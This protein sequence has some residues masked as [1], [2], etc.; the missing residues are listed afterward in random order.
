MISDYEGDLSELLSQVPS[1]DSVPVLA[2]RNMVLFPGVIVPIMIGRKSSVA[3]IKR[4]KK[5]PDKLCAVF[6][7]KDSNVDSPRMADLYLTGVYARLMKVL[8]M[9]DGENY[10]AIVQ[11]LGRCRL[12]SLVK[13]SPFLLGKTTP[14]KEELADDKD[15]MFAM[16]FGD[17]KQKV[18]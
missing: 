15:E 13:T 16:A 9:P 2:T 12:D 8:E 6:C 10:T 5:N 11:G 18:L 3:L 1:E 7:Q 17:L 14:L 4:L